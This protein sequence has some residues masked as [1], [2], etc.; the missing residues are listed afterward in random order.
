MGD[1]LDDLFSALEM[2][3]TLKDVGIERTRFY[4]LAETSLLDKFA[5]TSSSIPLQSKEQV[6]EILEMVAGVQ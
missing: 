6:L 2:P 1:A 4:K 5:K 3:W